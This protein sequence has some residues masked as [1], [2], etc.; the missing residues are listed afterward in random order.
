VPNTDSYQG[1]SVYPTNNEISG[2]SAAGAVME[3]D[4]GSQA[5]V[6]FT[7]SV[8]K[9]GNGAVSSTPSGISC[10]ATCSADF[11]S[12]TSVTLSATPDTGWAFSGWSG[13]CTGTG[14]CVLSM[15]AD[16]SATATFT[17]I[18]PP[19]APSSLTATSVRSRKVN[20]TWVDNSS[21]ETGF[22]IERSINQSTWTQVATTAANIK[23]Y[24]NS[25]LTAGTTYYYRVRAYNGSGD[26]AYSNTAS[27]KAI[28]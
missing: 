28:R 11:A 9:S 26:S 2:I 3:F 16:R 19:N 25:S 27:A 21:N 15:T 6:S 23:T 12:G 1:G 17:V 10:G 24:L 4:F 13:A 7:L 20:L 22:K 18:L 5:P 8:S 14:S